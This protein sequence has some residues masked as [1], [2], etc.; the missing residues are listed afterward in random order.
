MRQPE[1]FEPTEATCDAVQDFLEA[2]TDM[3]S[4]HTGETFHLCKLCGEV[5]S[6]TDACP[7]PALLKWQ[8]V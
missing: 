2:V 3:Q 6:H 1:P 5:D 8:G 7:V 4:W